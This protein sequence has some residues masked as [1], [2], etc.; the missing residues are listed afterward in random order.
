MSILLFLLS[1]SHSVVSLHQENLKFSLYRQDFIETQYHNEN[2]TLNY[3]IKTQGSNDPLILLHGFGGN[4]IWTWGNNLRKLQKDR[5]ILIP[6]L[7]WFGK[8]SSKS[9]PTLQLQ[10]QELLSV[11][12]ELG[13]ERYDIV[14]VSYGGFVALQMLSLSPSNIDDLILLD[15]PGP[16]FSE[17][18]IPLI[19]QRLNAESVEDIFVPTTPDAVQQ[20][21]DLCYYKPPPPMPARLLEQTYDLGFSTHHQEKRQLLRELP[22]NKDNLAKFKGPWPDS[23]V[24]WGEYD[25]VFPIASGQQFAESIGAEFTV[26][27]NAAHAPNVEFPKQFE[28]ILYQF[29]QR[30]D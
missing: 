4:A 7:L 3:W 23:L 16:I 9:E 18:E 2:T 14:G 30:P 12:Q 25:Q 10:A 5:P 28:E 8:S 17:E 13:W 29:L 15:S 6:D 21:I 24:I 11:I 22:Q 26:I 1:C 27:N 20:L 19:A